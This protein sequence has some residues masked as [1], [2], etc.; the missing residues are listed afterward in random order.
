MKHLSF[1]HFNF[2][3]ICVADWLFQILPMADPLLD[4]RGEDD[5]DEDGE[6]GGGDI[7]IAQLD[8]LCIDHWLFVLII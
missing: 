3:R 8:Y 2:E 5:E 1:P 4:E 7:L 6:D